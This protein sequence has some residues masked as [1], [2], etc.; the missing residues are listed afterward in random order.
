MSTVCSGLGLPSIP[1]PL[2]SRLSTLDFSNNKLQSLSASTLAMVP[3][4]VLTHLTIASNSITLLSADSL[5]MFRTLKW[6]SLANN[7]LTALPEGLLD[8]LNELTGLILEG[9]RFTTIPTLPPLPLL[10]SLN[11]NRNRIEVFRGQPLLAVSNHLTALLVQGFDNGDPVAVDADFLKNL[12]DLRTLDISDNNFGT[13]P[14]GLF[15]APCSKT[16]T[17]I[18]IRVR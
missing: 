4:L 7:M 9:N 5:Q 8:N 13:M 17:S 18:T 1:T 6:L 12:T 15:D 3:N 14:D 16:L 11:L 10:Q 2:D